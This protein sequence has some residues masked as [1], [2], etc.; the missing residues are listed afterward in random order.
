MGLWVLV[1][2]GLALVWARGGAPTVA[3]VLSILTGAAATV[4]FLVSGTTRNDAVAT[5][6]EQLA[7]ATGALAE[8]VRRQ[9]EPEARRRMLGEQQRLPLRCRFR[10]GASAEALDCDDFV[11]GFVDA[12]SRVVVVG[13]AGAGKTGLCL[14][15]TLEVLSRPW[16]AR[17]PVLLNIASWNPADNLEGW[18]L[19]RLLELYPFLGNRSRYGAGAAAEILNRD[20]VLVLLD[21]LDEMAPAHRAAALRAID[22]DLGGSRPLVL[23]SRGEAFA[24]ANESGVVSDADVVEIL[25]LDSAEIRDYLV[26]VT[27]QAAIAKWEPVL[28]T[29]AEPSGGVV[30][31]ALRTPLMLSLARSVYGEPGTE[32]GDLVRAAS[33]DDVETALLDCFPKQAFSTRPPSPLRKLARRPPEWDPDRAERWLAFLAQR[34]QEVAWWNLWRIVPRWVF[35]LRGVLVGGVLAALMGWLL[36]GLFGEPV[37]GVRLGAAVGVVGGVALGLVPADLPRRF[38]ARVPNRHE[39]PRDLLFALVGAVAG[40]V[41]V[42]W[43]FG[44]WPGVVIGL[45]CG[46]AYGGVRR[47]GEPVEPG[48]AITPDSVMRDDKRAVRL[49]VGFGAVTG[50]LAGGF[51][52]GVVGVDDLGLVVPITNPVLTGLLGGGV[53]LLLGAGGLGLATHA[54]SASGRFAMASVWLA[55]TRRTPLRL[56][57]F[58]R[59]AQQL[60]VL[61]SAGPVYQFRHERLRDRLARRA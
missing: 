44:W 35:V 1:V 18:L 54:T 22:S 11:N 5:S 8:E 42:G 7:A 46:V 38:V 31:Q 26:A 34:Y 58:L 37:L 36:F 33:A 30:G 17:V 16:E 50:L 23:T 24:A 3:I 61:R 15:L 20:R 14:L 49:A 13:E 55:L 59:D 40:G 19:D 9:W 27:P 32:P 47:F 52:G 48:R 57:A 41:A 4:Q 45:F 6:E 43:I 39:L 53:G 56:M 29:L 2:V 10:R 12:P 25:P 60:G 21:G 28:G 51:L